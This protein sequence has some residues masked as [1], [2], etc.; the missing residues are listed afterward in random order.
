MA[1]FI[2]SEKNILFLCLQASETPALKL[3]E[4]HSH[5][6]RLFFV[7][8]QREQYVFLGD[9]KELADLATLEICKIWVT[10]NSNSAALRFFSI[11]ILS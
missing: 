1:L 9:M 8:K 3:G 7:S 2:I 4:S 5:H 10:L 11:K 6:F